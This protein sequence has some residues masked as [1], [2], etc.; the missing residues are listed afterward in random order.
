VSNCKTDRLSHIFYLFLLLFITYLLIYYKSIL[1]FLLIYGYNFY[2][3][4]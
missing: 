1:I 4:D 3:T 2:I